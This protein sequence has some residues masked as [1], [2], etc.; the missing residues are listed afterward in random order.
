MP[1]SNDE[2]PHANVVNELGIASSKAAPARPSSAM[3]LEGGDR[4]FTH[5]QHKGQT[6]EEVSRKIEYVRWALLQPSPAA[7]IR[8]FLFLFE[9]KAKYP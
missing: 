3:Q 2:D 5:G 4:R 6:Y 7:N 9:P 1:S 8:D